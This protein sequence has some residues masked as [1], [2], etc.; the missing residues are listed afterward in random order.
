M[1]TALTVKL[2]V[3]LP[4]AC[5]EYALADPYCLEP[6]RRLDDALLGRDETHLSRARPARLFQHGVDGRGRHRERLRQ[7]A[8]AQQV[9]QE[10]SRRR[11]PG[12]VDLKRQQRRL[13]QPRPFP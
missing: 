12:A 11:V 4:R 6:P 10:Q 8:A 13:D 3:T 5:Y 7:G 2:Y 9:R 1:T